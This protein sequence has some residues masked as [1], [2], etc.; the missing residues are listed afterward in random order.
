MVRT[1]AKI[2]MANLYKFTRW[3]GSKNLNAMPRRPKSQSSQPGRKTPAPIR[4]GVC[5]LKTG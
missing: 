3:P 2:G 5:L 1:R 4:Q